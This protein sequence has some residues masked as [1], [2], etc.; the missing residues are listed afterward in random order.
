V[1]KKGFLFFCLLLFLAGILLALPQK[2]KSPKDL[3]Q[4]YRKWLEEEVVYIITPKE[5][6]VFLQLETDRERDVFIEAFWKQRDPDLS[7]PENEF[8]KEHYRRINYANQWFGRESPGLGWRTDMG[9]IYIILGEP[10]YIERYENVTEVFPTII[11][12]YEGLIDYGLP[13]SFNVVFFKKSGMGEYELYSPVKNGPESLLTNYMG[14]LADHL[15]AY[16]QLMEVEPTI[17]EVS[18]TLIPEEAGWATSPSIASELL[19]RNK[20]P[21]APYQKV[22]DSY[23]EKLLKYKDIIEVDYTAN[24]IDNDACTE[25]I[26]DKSGMAFVHYIIEPKR[27]TFEQVGNR[28]RANL[29]LNGKITDLQGNTIYQY[30]R[31]VP[32]DFDQEQLNSVKAKLFSFQDMV[33]IVEGNY[34][35][36]ILLKNTVSKEFT[37]MEK[38]ISVPGPSSLQ[39]SHLLLANK[40]IENSEYK[41]KNKPF[42]IGDVQLVPSPRNDFS[43]SDKLYLF[44]QVTGLTKDLKE[45][46]RLE[47]SIIKEKETISSFAKN[48]RDYPDKMNFREE[49][50]LA[51]LSSGYYKIKVSLFDK[52]SQELL[53]EQSNFFISYLPSLPRPWVLSIP[54]PSSE[55]PIYD[56]ILGIQFFN[57]KDMDKAKLLLGEAY[58]KNP[59]SKEFALDFCRALFLGK[60]YQKVKDIARPFLQSQDKYE[61]LSLAGDSCQAL[62][63]LAEAIAHYKE[64]LAHYGANI[65]ILNAIGQCYYQ[66]GDFE[67]AL[68]AWEKS[69][70]ISPNQESIKKMV[71]AIKEKK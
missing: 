51:N 33:P 34:K 53:F 42:L 11:W 62:G 19:I 25:I 61:F 52:N 49:F 48:I 6:E 27:L 16:S 20:I 55:N 14:D 56:N 18:M 60:E 50:S 47:Y 12:F 35:L 37:S 8:M 13:N 70:E 44:F 23:A 54:L 17:A 41:G 57:K 29:Q 3:P 58:R 59:S 1:N 32:I 65:N 10:K 46:G 67:E 28:F 39:F 69:L 64:Y 4:Q 36:N 22:K 15:A 63:E 30:E 38:D 7:T 43:A 24:Y 21:S 5:K 66:L 71:K 26:R 9:R 2:K 45:N 40:T 68:I 31:S